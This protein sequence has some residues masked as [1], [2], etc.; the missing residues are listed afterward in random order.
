MTLLPLIWNRISAFTA[1]ALVSA[2]MFDTVQPMIKP[3]S[4]KLI[5]EKF[6][7][8]SK[9]GYIPFFYQSQ[10]LFL[11]ILNHDAAG[12]KRD[13]YSMLL[14]KANDVLI[15]HVFNVKKHIFGA[16]L[17]AI[18]FRKRAADSD[19]VQLHEFP[20]FILK[21][22]KE[23]KQG[24]K[25]GGGKLIV[26]PVFV[27]GFHEIGKIN[28]LVHDNNLFIW[29]KCCCVEIDPRLKRANCQEKFFTRFTLPYGNYN[30]DCGGGLS[31][32]TSFNVKPRF[33]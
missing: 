23:F 9:E 2:T 4:L 3:L 29:L 32:G 16:I 10:E 14:K 18:V 33:V 31:Y 24:F 26:A 20:S 7:N 21:F 17:R 28:T 5:F 8:H 11:I 27:K 6:L 25:S 30:L 19:N 22:F 13:N 12:F 15:F 1:F